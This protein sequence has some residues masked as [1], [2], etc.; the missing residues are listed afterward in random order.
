MWVT[1]AVLTLCLSFFAWGYLV[2]AKYAPDVEGWAPE[3]WRRR[4]CEVCDES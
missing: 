3:S 1:I 2:G 4:R